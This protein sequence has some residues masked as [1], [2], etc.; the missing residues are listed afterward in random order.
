MIPLN[1]I[2]ASEI[3]KATMVA[4]CVRL[5]MRRHEFGTSPY[6]DVATVASAMVNVSI[7]DP[8]SVD[9]ENQLQSFHLFVVTLQC[10]LEKRMKEEGVE[11]LI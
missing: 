4:E 5:L 1:Q 11:P 2:P 8:D 9:M 3:G 6:Q 7:L 10:E